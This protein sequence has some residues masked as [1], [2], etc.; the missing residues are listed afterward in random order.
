MPVEEGF[1]PLI[2]LGRM[3]AVLLLVGLNA[4]FVMI[5]FSVVSARR[6]RL[7]R[8]AEQG[9]PQAKKALK[10]MLENPDRVIA[11]AQVGVTLASLAIGA[12]GEPT[13]RWLFEPLLEAALG[14]WNPWLAS[15]I[16]S[17]FSLGIITILHSVLGEQ[18]PKTIAIRSAESSSK[19]LV[20][21]V[22]FFQ[23]IAFPFVQLMEWL[24]GMT[25]HAL[26]KKPLKGHQTL[27]N[28][29]EIQ[30]M[31]QESEQGGIVARS[32]ADMAQKV[33]EFG[34]LRAQEVMIPRIDIVGIP[35]DFTISQ[36]LAV[37]QKTWHAR[38]PVYNESLDEI[39]G[40]ISIKEILN[41][42]AENKNYSAIP[43]SKLARPVMA[44]P[45]SRLVSSLLEEMRH[46]HRQM[47][48]VLDEY[49]G[50][51][52][53]VTLEELIEEI[54]GKVSDELFKEAPP[55][56]KVSAG[57]Y[58]VN[59][60]LRVTELNEALKFS[61]PEHQEYDTLAGL[62]LYRLKKVPLAGDKYLLPGYEI[63]VEKMK[64]PKIEKALIKIIPHGRSELAQAKTG[65]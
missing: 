30:Q 28:A 21:S 22:Q 58:R 53:I 13:L 47:A 49:G 51:A 56:V 5:E 26:G 38:Y 34:D 2:F 36:M 65:Q 54:I 55:I 52:G 50:T 17:V 59:A 35:A 14:Q 60:Q 46:Q 7:E 20:N 43:I 29:D 40:T 3:G 48:V 6:I 9:D 1:T 61:L 24:T 62:L 27:Y 15:L 44:V 42:I 19:A 63:T 18:V 31:L 45:D 37:Y 11:V 39:T 4:I 12:I 32:Q 10:V 64:G 57:L 16:S 23:A 25:L 41:A 8:M 33:F